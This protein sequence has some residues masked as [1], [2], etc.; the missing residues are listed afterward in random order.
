MIDEYL[1]H[2][3]ERARLGIPPLPLSAEQTAGL[4]TLLTDPP[5]GR[6]EFLLTLLEE[7]VS[8]GVDP[9]AR[10]KADFLAAIV[11]GSIMSPLLKPGDAIRILGGM[12]GGYNVDPLMA[13]LADAVVA[14]EAA[15]ELSRITL[16]HG[17]FDQLAALV[18][19]GNL[20]ASRV[21]NSWAE[22]EWFTRRAALPATLRLKVYRVEGEIN[23]DDF[24]PAGDAWSRPDIP[25]HAL[26]M[27]RSRFPDGLATMASF[28]EEGYRVAFVGDVIGT[29]SSRKSACNSL[30]WAIGDDIPGVPNK[31][32]GA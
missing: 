30:L 9:A 16:I 23:T 19:G 31:R 13:A 10:V 14:D 7:R 20:A 8:P 17:A 6:E 5:P 27:G 2:E 21:M 18:R 28:R 26:A 24:S 12:L 25:L 11:S 15:T 29:G 22:G 4:C 1:Q 3:Q 32:G